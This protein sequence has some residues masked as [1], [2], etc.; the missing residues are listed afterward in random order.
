MGQVS[1][2]HVTNLL[3][4]SCRVLE[5]SREELQP[6]DMLALVQLLSQAA[7]L[8]TGTDPELDT[9]SEGNGSRA[10]AGELS[11]YFITLADRIISQDN[12]P[13][14]QAIKQVPLTQSDWGGK[15]T[16]RKSTRLNS[17]H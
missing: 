3:D 13:K 10:S 8:P 9:P 15:Q 2:G 4:A 12:A 17:S 14:W 11:E 16:D 7:D 5:E 1:W 6:G